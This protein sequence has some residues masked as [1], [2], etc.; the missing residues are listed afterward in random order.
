MCDNFRNTF[1]ETLIG[2]LSISLSG[3]RHMGRFVGFVRVL[4][5]LGVLG[6][7]RITL[8][9]GGQNFDDVRRLYEMGTSPQWILWNFLLGI[10]TIAPDFLA[11]HSYVPIL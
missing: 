6:M 1:A 11:H 9:E 7:R 10:F 5:F 4:A 8:D 3:I 2:Y